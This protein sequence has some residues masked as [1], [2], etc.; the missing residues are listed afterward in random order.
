MA[1][2]HNSKPLPATAIRDH[3]TEDGAY[4]KRRL[5][6]NVYACGAEL[7][8]P[9]CKNAQQ[10]AEAMYG[11]QFSSAEYNLAQLVPC[12]THHDNDG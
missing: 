8:M 9:P 7:I 12:L 10:A 11:A 3:V 1:L 5:H 2:L 4:N 6:R